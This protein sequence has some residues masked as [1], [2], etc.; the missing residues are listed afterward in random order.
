VNP[1]IKNFLKLYFNTFLTKKRAKTGQ[2]LLK[3][4]SKPSILTLFNKF[5][6]GF[7]RFKKY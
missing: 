5:S 7:E 3:I 6:T 1:A 2:K 4:H